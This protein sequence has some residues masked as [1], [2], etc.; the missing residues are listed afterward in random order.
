MIDTGMKRGLNLGCGILNMGEHLI[1]VDI[2]RTP[3]VVAR[4]V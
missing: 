3:L 4:T 2:R 1:N